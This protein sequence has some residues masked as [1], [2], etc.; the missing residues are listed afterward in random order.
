[1]PYKWPPD[2]KCVTGPPTTAQAPI[3]D[4]CVGKGRLRH[5]WGMGVREAL[6]SG[7]VVPAVMG[8]GVEA[9]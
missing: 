7:I 8:S 6:T 5:V 2:E 3:G 4:T 9:S 1:M